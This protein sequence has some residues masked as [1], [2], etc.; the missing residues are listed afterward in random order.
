MDVGPEQAPPADERDVLPPEAPDLREHSHAMDFAD[1]QAAGRFVRDSRLGG[2]FHA[3]KISLR[4]DAPKGSLHVSLSEDNRVSVH[5]DRFSP[6]GDP[7]PGGRRGYSVRRVIVH[8]VGI[9]VDYVILFFQRRFGQQR[10]ELECERVCADEH[11]EQG[12]SPATGPPCPPLGE[13]R[14]QS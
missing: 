10:C 1:L 8:N 11:D 12:T 6:L 2:M 9:V 14:S 7:R 5:L 3:G 13:E 4:E